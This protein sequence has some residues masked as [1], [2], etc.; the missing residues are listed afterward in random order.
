MLQASSDGSPSV[1]ESPVQSDNLDRHLTS[2]KGTDQVG[3]WNGPPLCL[4]PDYP[5][6]IICPTKHSN[7]VKFYLYSVYPSANYNFVLLVVKY[8]CVAYS[9]HNWILCCLCDNLPN[10]HCCPKAEVMSN[11]DL[12]TNPSL[13]CQITRLK[14]GH[15]ILFVKVPSTVTSGC[16]S[17]SFRSDCCRV[18]RISSLVARW[19]TS[20]AFAASQL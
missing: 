9:L 15:T 18:I 16:S 6:I 13:R 3:A 11:R 4:I 8:S 7:F 10:N 14:T 17:C 12:N 1:V 2:K 20:C 19:Q 5:Y